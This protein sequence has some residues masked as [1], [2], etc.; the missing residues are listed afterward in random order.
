MLLNFTCDSFKG[1]INILCVLSVLPERLQVYHPEQHH[2]TEERISS[3]NTP[4]SLRKKC[5][6]LGEMQLS[7]S[8]ASY[9]S[10]TFNLSLGSQTATKPYS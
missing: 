3:G 7:S 2:R 5:L 4:V 10:L 1:F 8:M 6:V 9:P